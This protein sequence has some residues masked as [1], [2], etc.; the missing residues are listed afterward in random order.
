MR[1][2][3]LRSRS[4]N[5]KETNDS[6]LELM[7]ELATHLNTHDHNTQSLLNWF[8]KEVNNPTDTFASIER[9]ALGPT[10]ITL[11]RYEIPAYCSINHLPTQ[12]TIHRYD[13]G[14]RRWYSL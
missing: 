11:W 8:D 9:L 3:L 7:Q 6:I 13:L 4:E 12:F 2:S 1:P 14:G 5:Q 10:L